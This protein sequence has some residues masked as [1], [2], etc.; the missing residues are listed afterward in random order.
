MD[1][2]PHLLFGILIALLVLGMILTIPRNTRIM[3]VILLVGG[4]G[5]YVGVSVQKSEWNPMN[6]DGDGDDTCTESDIKDNRDT[7][8]AATFS[9]DSDDNCVIATCDSGYVLNG[10]TCS[11]SAMLGPGGIQPVPK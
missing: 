7:T 3:G 9:R 1:T 8:N 11:K 10:L 2:P 5:M 4:L 6:W